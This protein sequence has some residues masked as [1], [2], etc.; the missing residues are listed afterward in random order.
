MND[1]Q[2]YEVTKSFIVYLTTVYL[3]LFLKTCCFLTLNR[4]VKFSSLEILFQKVSCDETTRA[5][6]TFST[7]V[8]LLIKKYYYVAH[9]D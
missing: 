4:T 7:K 5:Q 8:V 2:F 6:G 9:I 1:T 3:I